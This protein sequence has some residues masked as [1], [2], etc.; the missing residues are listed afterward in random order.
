M[1]TM[2]QEADF[3]GDRLRLS[4]FLR[5]VGNGMPKPPKRF[6][7]RVLVTDNSLEPSTHLET[8]Q[9]ATTGAKKVSGELL[10]RVPDVDPAG[11][12]VPEQPSSMSGILFTAP[13]IGTE[14]GAESES[15][16]DVRVVEMLPRLE[17]RNPII[18][19]T[20]M[21]KEPYKAPKHR[22]KRRMPVNELALL[23]TTSSDGLPLPSVRGYL[24][25]R[26]RW[27]KLIRA[28]RTIIV[29]LRRLWPSP[30]QLRTRVGFCHVRQFGIHS[31]SNE[32]PK[33]LQSL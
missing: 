20:P 11:S 4:A 15:Q 9:E 22:R 32:W 23:R 25:G 19:K 1:L 24:V 6:R 10:I 26:Y 16:E 13:E 33:P 12:Q 29:H 21:S 7:R 28:S 27:L 17:E 14:G 5:V 30:I 2:P 31:I 3:C 18:A 8:T